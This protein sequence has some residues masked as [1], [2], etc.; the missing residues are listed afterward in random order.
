MGVWVDQRNGENVLIKTPTMESMAL[1]IAVMHKQAVQHTSLYKRH[2]VHDG[3]KH[4]E[5]FMERWQSG[6]LRPP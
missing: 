5:E 3:P 6:L 2:V 1:S 4:H